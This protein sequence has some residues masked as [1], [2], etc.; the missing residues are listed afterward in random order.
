MTDKY[1]LDGEV[2]SY[3]DIKLLADDEGVSVN[4]YVEGY[5][6]EVQ[7]EEESKDLPKP[8]YFANLQSGIL[9]NKK[10]DTIK[11]IRFKDGRELFEQEYLDYQEKNPN[12]YNAQ[13]DWDT[14]VKMQ[15]QG[16]RLVDLN[17]NVIKEGDGVLIKTYDAPDDETGEMIPMSTKDYE[18]KDGKVILKENLELDESKIEDVGGRGDTFRDTDQELEYHLASLEKIGDYNNPETNKKIADEYFNAPGIG[19]ITEGVFTYKLTDYR[20]DVTYKNMTKKQFEAAQKGFGRGGVKAEMIGQV[21]ERD[22][23]V[24]ILGEEKTDDYLK[25]LETGVLDI[26]GSKNKTIFN[27][28]DKVT[29]DERDK[30]NQNFM[31]DMSRD[32]RT[33][34]IANMAE[35]VFGDPR[36]SKEVEARRKDEKDY[37][38]YWKKNFNRDLKLTDVDIINGRRFV[39]LHKSETLRKFVKFEKGIPD[40]REFFQPRVDEM[41]KRGE[42]I[43]IKVDA[44]KSDLNDFIENS[45]PLQDEYNKLSNDLKALGDVNE[46]SSADVI[47][48][49]N[50]I[51]TQIG[52]LVLKYEEGGFLE[53]E[54]NLSNR[55]KQ[56]MEET[57]EFEKK[58]GMLEDVGL[59]V[60]AARKNYSNWDRLGLQ[61]EK[62]FLGGGAT[63][64][65]G[66]LLEAPQSVA[67]QV[68]ELATGRETEWENEAYKM[69]NDYYQRLEENLQDKYER[70][71]KLGETNRGSFWAQTLADQTPSIISVLAP[72]G[73]A[74]LL[75]TKTL[76]SLGGAAMTRGA[77]NEVRNRALRKLLYKKASNLTM[78]AMFVQS[79]G[80]ALGQSEL[81][82]LKAPEQIKGLE[83]ILADPNITPDDRDYYQTM[84]ENAEASRDA[85]Y[86]SK[87]LNSIAYGAIEMYAEKLGSLRYIQNFKTAR[88]AVSNLSNPVFRFAHR[89]ALNGW[90]LSKSVG[91]GVGI[92]FMEEYVTQ[93]GQNASD[94][95]LMGQDKALDEGVD[96]TFFAKTAITSL[97]LQGGNIGNNLYNIAASE[98]R[99]VRETMQSRKLLNELIRVENEL[100]KPNLGRAK[101]ARLINRKRAILRKGALQSV[102]SLQ[103]LNNLTAEEKRDLFEQARLRRRA[104]R[105]IYTARKEGA[106]Q[107]EI[108]N[109]IEQFNGYEAA[110]NQYASKKYLEDF[111]A[112]KKA[113]VLNA[114]QAADVAALNDMYNDIAEL[115]NFNKGKAFNKF[116]L[117]DVKDPVEFTERILK[118]F[119]TKK[120]RRILKA[121]SGGSYSME[122]DGDIFTFQDNITNAIMSNNYTEA[123]IAAVSPLHEVLHDELRK[124][125][126]DTGGKISRRA[127]NAARGLFKKVE[128][129]YKDGKLTKEQF[130]TFKKRFDLYNTTRGRNYIELITLVNDMVAIGAL[131]RASFS[132][133]YDIKNWMNSLVQRFQKGGEMFYEFKT[134]ED[135][136]RYITRFGDKAR[137]GDIVGGE[138]EEQAGQAQESRAIDTRTVDEI[139]EQEGIMGYEAILEKKKPFA[140]KLVRA[141]DNRANYSVYKDIL[142]DDVLTGKRGILELIMG[143]PA[144]VEK[145]N[146]AGEKVAPLDAYINNALSPRGLNRILEIVN[147]RLGSEEGGQ[148]TVKLDSETTFL[149]VE[150]GSDITGTMPSFVEEQTSKLRKAFKIAKGSRLYNKIIE[151]VKNAITPKVITALQGSS[152][153]IKTRKTNWVLANPKKFR[154]EL[155]KSFTEA[156]EKTVSD[157]IGTQKSKKFKN[158]ITTEKKLIQDLL[159]IKYKKRFSFMTKSL[160]RLSAEESRQSQTSLGGSYVSDDYAGNQKYEKVELT[161]QDMLDNF[162]AGRETQYKSLKKSLAAEMGLD[163]TFDAILD[164]DSPASKLK[165]VTGKISEA[166]KRDPAVN[167]SRTLHSKVDIKGKADF[168]KNKDKFFNELL[169]IPTYDKKGVRQAFNRVFNKQEHPELWEQRDGIIN[170]FAGYLKGFNEYI[171]QFKKQPP[172][173]EITKQVN[174]A[175]DFYINKDIKELLN[176]DQ[177]IGPMFNDNKAV[178]KQ[179]RFYLSMKDALIEQFGE[180]QGID[181]FLNLV[182]DQIKNAGKVADGN[183][184]WD[185]ELKQLVKN[186]AKRSS[187]QSYNVY[188]T[189]LDVYKMLDLASHGVIMGRPGVRKGKKVT[190][191]ADQFFRIEKDDNGND[192]YVKIRATGPKQSSPG[193]QEVIDGNVD[194]KARKAD[195]KK[196]R[197]ILKWQMQFATKLANNKK[198]EFGAD[199]IAMMLAGLS[200]NMSTALR[201]A[202]LLKYVPVNFDYSNQGK[203]YEYEHMIPAK[204]IVTSLIKKYYLKEKLDIDKL[205]DDYNV[206]V[207]P[208][209]MNDVINMF[210][211]SDMHIGYQIGDNILKRYYNFFTEGREMYALK[212]IESGD[213]VGK[214]HENL[215]KA[216]QENKVPDPADVEY[217][218]TILENHSKPIGPKKGISVFDFDDTLARSNSKVGVTMPDG[219]KRKINATEFALESADLEAAGA[220]FDFSEFNKVIEGK[221]GPLF[222]LAMRRQDKFTSKDIFILTARPQEAAYAIHAFL[223][224]M[225]LNIP[226]NNIVGLADGRPEAK[227]DWVANKIKDG[228][229]DFYFADDAYKNVKAVQQLLEQFDVKSD[230][231][232]AKVNE[233][234][235]LSTDFNKIIEKNKGIKADAVYSKIVAKRMGSTKGKY[236]F[237]L[238]PNAE[239]FKGLIYTMLGKGRDGDAQF[240]W[241]K[242][243]LI[244]PYTAGIAAMNLDKT[245]VTTTWK[246][247]LKSYPDVKKKLKQLIPGSIFTYDHALRV[248]MW[249]KQG[250]PIPGLSKRDTS[251]LLK[252]VNND[253]KLENF[254]NDLL[255]TKLL[256]GKG[257]PAPGEYWDADT[258][259]GELTS[260]ADIGGRKTYLAKWIK[261]KNE[262]FTPDNLNKIEANY[263]TDF[264]NA[265]E[266]ILWRMENGTNR[267]FGTNKTVNEFQD[268]INNAVGAVMFINVRSATLQTIS[269]ANF[270]NW[271]DNNFMKAAIAFANQ[272][273]YWKDW[274]MI[275][276]SPKLLARRRG[277]Q[278][279]VQEQ[280][281]AN[282]ANKGGV[283]GALAYLLR[284][285]FTPTQMADSFAIAS[286]GASFYRNR[287]NTYKKQGLDEKAAEEKAFKDFSDIAEETQQSGDPALISEIQAGAL[288]RPIFSWQN[289][290]FQYNRLMKRAGQDLINRR[291]YPGMS[292]FQSDITNISKILY[293]GMIQNFI[294][295][296]MQSALFAMLPGFTGDE[297]EDEEKQQDKEAAKIERVANN[298]VD[299]ILRGSGLPGAVVSTVKNIL[300]EYSKQEDK[301]FLADHTYTL[302]QAINL[303]PPIGSKAR[304]IYGGIQTLRFDKDVIAERGYGIDSPIWQAIGNFTSAATNFPLDR[305]VAILNN[306]TA[307]LDERNQAWQRVA[308]IMGWNTWDVG[309]KDLEA[310]EIKA[311]AKEIRKL[312]GIEKAKKTRA[313]KKRKEKEAKRKEQ[314][315]KLEEMRKK[316]EE[317]KIKIN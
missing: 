300:M 174:A 66:L 264:R 231:Q 44:Y 121:W 216:I 57:S 47:N 27:D 182:F 169:N 211:K 134:T 158:F 207:V 184:K 202:G 92:E 290:P 244:D 147:K 19:P 130:E 55:S 268:W 157:I 281:L 249:N 10:D 233:S 17:G 299:T 140:Q 14:Y 153:E 16:G 24:K 144:Y 135:V 274:V 187:R 150:D 206:A 279:N 145:Q 8:D 28:V 190:L 6:I 262:I 143:Y 291:R 172:K 235:A 289:T 5:G 238:P 68:Y 313:E 119:G 26:D 179:H 230:V 167:F 156:F 252:I 64:L 296:A 248:Y 317:G 61:L 222:D 4:D 316:L 54:K 103:K 7:K 297:D 23:L 90:G 284:I 199:N 60:D 106:N 128:Q 257:Y 11:F 205:L 194:M 162:V 253:S 273:Q 49:Y 101:R 176:L 304:K 306:T 237:Y 102:V 105:D 171:K 2:Y 138:V 272:P 77:F 189:N 245:K 151:E 220:K 133:L 115:I 213:I 177:D 35:V 41:N 152:S 126:I 1:L 3:D 267:R 131:D 260:T 122:I 208:G 70:S 52:D 270:I 261:N 114:G 69:A 258:L 310:E 74:R 62:A 265:L 118:E 191:D 247:L 93:L 178:E 308:M 149:Q 292:Q 40:A 88:N 109:L 225:G 136:Y 196:N 240:A 266:D 79:A 89:S 96:P 226:I 232:Q 183:S 120:G 50:K 18:V 255:N 85:G 242:R 107:G 45:K 39:P 124:L 71:W 82:A 312:E 277:L 94:I 113:G 234:K 286:G 65:T 137:S 37:N 263:G 180:K 307:A 197:D 175:F 84:L 212:D 25:Y 87:A 204:Y 239:D 188:A 219:S 282:A 250:M 15:R 110:R 302:I 165:A 217:A 173:K 215:Y 42:E 160:G 269:M 91:K 192:V 67:E 142:V 161:D 276:N 246:T 59:V 63:L 181:M 146:E 218:Q 198:S 72:T 256:E 12:S 141:F 32:E 295:T 293:Y 305:A 200:S 112:A 280:E 34:Y 275:W 21:N 228:Y 301:G 148:F 166:I 117:D 83:K 227:A 259:L 185:Y 132:K 163:A 201:R 236:Q 53:A 78:S 22:D 127:L 116:T 123:Q 214:Y 271:S 221:K 193:N 56:L 155:E 95:V 99:N 81:A 58:A 251:Q 298:M 195:A 43:S 48:K 154:Q 51:A 129:K 98:V 314:E 229:N 80:A 73:A 170:D 31:N 278:L 75:T 209:N 309:V 86:F 20:G 285:G 315:K 164:E 311:K 241:F 76:Q 104:I 283:K 30:L 223:K 100:Q 36:L 254:A 29:R 243:N 125:G 46:N 33:E 9:K 224:G 186:D 111:K 108:D 38:D 13:N 294:F 210:Y 139:Y 159:A 287:V 288:G 97:A 203:D 303:S 168:M